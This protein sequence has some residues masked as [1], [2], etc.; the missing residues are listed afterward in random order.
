MSEHLCVKDIAWVVLVVRKAGYV[1][2]RWMLLV[3][4]RWRRCENHPLAVHK[5]IHTPCLRSAFM[6]QQRDYMTSVILRDK[7]A[8][9]LYTSQGK[10][11]ET[12]QCAPM[13]HS[14]CTQ[15]GSASTAS[16][17]CLTRLFSIWTVFRWLTTLLALSPS[18]LICSVD[19]LGPAHR[20]EG[21]HRRRTQ[22]G[23]KWLLSGGE[24]CHVQHH[25]NSFMKVNGDGVCTLGLRLMREGRCRYEV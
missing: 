8:F 3:V 10:S 6:T 4:G 25:I 1:G 15:A 24:W 18:V 21:C 2:T 5:C 19:T 16:A 23:F 14:P 7:R 13:N 9:S 22:T 20:R 17:E 12:Q 11:L